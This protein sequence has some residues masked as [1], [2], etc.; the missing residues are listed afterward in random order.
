MK[1]HDKEQVDTV[2]VTIREIMARPTFALGAADAR[3]GRLYHNDY[4]LWDT[5]DQW[6]Y[7]R[8]RQWAT[9]AP[10]GVPLRQG[11]KLTP[12]AVASFKL[13]DLDII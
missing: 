2:P 12:E 6:A 10:R 3:A 1:D 13:Y 11:G 5:N 7:E 9:L 8:G 4:D